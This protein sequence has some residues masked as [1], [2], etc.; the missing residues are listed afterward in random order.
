M[1]CNLKKVGLPFQCLDKTEENQSW[2][3]LFLLVR[4][5]PLKFSQN[6]YKNQIQHDDSSN[7]STQNK[8]K[9][10]AKTVN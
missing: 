1:H 4:H 6:M 5:S 10:T 9:N 3:A 7:A 8:F 2:F